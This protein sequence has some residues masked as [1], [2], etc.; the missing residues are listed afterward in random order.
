[1]QSNDCSPE[2]NFKFSESYD[3]D[4]AMNSEGT[5]W[6]FNTICFKARE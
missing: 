2:N 4:F 6:E 3:K 5:I 1:M